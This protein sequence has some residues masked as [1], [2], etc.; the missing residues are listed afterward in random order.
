MIPSPTL[1]AMSTTEH[2]VASLN[3]I[4][5]GELRD[6]DAGG[7]KVLLAR[8][9][10][11]VY[12]TQAMCPH[13]GLPLSDGGTIV[14]GRIRCPYHMSCFRAS[15]G[16]VI[17][18]PA[19]DGLVSFPCRVDADGRV[20]VTVDTAKAKQPS[21][22]PPMPRVA[23]TSQRTVLVIGSGAGG[24]A[25]IQRLCE[26]DF[27]G[28]VV[29]LTDDPSPLPYDRPSLSKAY[30][31][32]EKPAEKLTPRDESFFDDHAIERVR[33]RAVAL[34]A[35]AKTVRLAD[36]ESLTYD[37]A[38][39][40]LGGTPIPL[41]VPGGDLARV[42]TLRTRVDCEQILGSLKMTKRAVVVGS[43]FI[44]MEA[45]AGLR[46]RG[47]DVTVVSSAATPFDSI[48]GDKV[49]RLFQQLHEKEGV[50][51]RLGTTIARCE[52][53]ARVERVVLDGGETIACDLVVVGIGVEP[54]TDWLEGALPLAKDGGIVVD[55]D[56]RVRGASDVY[57]VGDIAPAPDPR[58]GEP[59]RIEHWRVA[60]Q[61]GRR[62]AGEIVGRPEPTAEAP[63][64]WSLQYKVGLDYVGHA[65]DFDE[66]RLDGDGADDFYAE[67]VKAGR[68][69]AIASVGRTDRVMRTIDAMRNDWRQ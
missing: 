47:V 63:Y 1:I 21:E 32:G 62:A 49:G 15:D 8:D 19:L 31:T 26:L 38:I 30:L 52:G 16:I 64:F 27:D 12:A 28:R 25:A 29:M 3:E 13:Y 67:Y 40:A 59:M 65:E 44:G 43:S 7:T 22:P 54:A 41:D 66:V 51:F 68:V 4:K 39:L 57:A 61:H 9:G 55:A 5:P 20:L 6:V 18:P 35:T 37:V 42:L 58:S 56:L 46:Q 14:D 50:A 11:R 2:D 10:D 34:D 23:A 69:L 33:G 60:Q 53:K 48:L 36:G 45:A 24:Y 17:E